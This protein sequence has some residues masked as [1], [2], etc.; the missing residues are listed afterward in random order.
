MK[1]PLPRFLRRKQVFARNAARFDCKIDGE[2]VL[3]ESDATYQGRLINLST[4]GAMFRPRLA[5]LLDHRGKPARLQICGV[6]VDAQIVAT[7][8]AGF[9]LRFEQPLDQATLLDI[10]GTQPALAA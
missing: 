6:A 10:I 7:T 1:L 5:Y 2:L 3:T 8:P 4:G 9:G